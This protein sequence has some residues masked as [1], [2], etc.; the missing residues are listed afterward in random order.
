MIATQII[1]ALKTELKQARVT[2][3]YLAKELRISEAG[4]KKMFTRQDVSLERILQIC[5]ILNLSFSEIIART[6]DTERSDLRFTKKQSDFLSQNIDFFH[7][8]MKL[9]YEQKSPKDI[10]EE[11][12]LNLKSL[13]IYLKKLE[14]IE[15][16][17]RHPRDRVQVVGGLQ[18]AVRTE[19]TALEKLKTQ[20][21]KDM[22][23][24]F[25][26]SRVGSLNGAGLQLTVS[27]SKEFQMRWEELIREFS[28]ISSR[29]RKAH[30]TGTQALS[31]MLLQVPASMF[32]SIHNF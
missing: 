23:A 11:F 20:T 9:A 8:Y 1:D 21:I 30:S 28:I 15:L 14:Q 5:K 7:F 16:I 22:L 25:E 2:Y 32:R 29:H 19:G 18:F 4:V 31:I 26:E 3:R 24:F 17:I 12:G 10:Q 13:N 27:E 6:E